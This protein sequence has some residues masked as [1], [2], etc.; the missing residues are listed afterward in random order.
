MKNRVK[1]NAVKINGC[2]SLFDSIWYLWSV[3]FIALG[4]YLS[5]TKQ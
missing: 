5:D 4:L 3:E 2:L 1:I